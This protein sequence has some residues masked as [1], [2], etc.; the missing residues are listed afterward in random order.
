[1]N[2]EED[3]ERHRSR[4][5]AIRRRSRSPVRNVGYCCDM[6]VIRQGCQPLP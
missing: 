4:H 2:V 6:P 1:M 5:A 3:E